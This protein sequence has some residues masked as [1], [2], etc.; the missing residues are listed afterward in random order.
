MRL[1]PNVPNPSFESTVLAGSP[2]GFSFY[3]MEILQSA[4]IPVRACWMPEKQEAGQL[5]L[6]SK[7]QR[8]R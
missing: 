8:G 5:D 7:E 6:N 3:G 2:A 1:L 4:T